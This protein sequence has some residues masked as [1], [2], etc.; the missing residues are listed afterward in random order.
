MIDGEQEGPMAL[1]D[2]GAQ[3]EE[4]LSEMMRDLDKAMRGNKAASQRVRTASVLFT[5]VAK[6]FRKESIAAEK[7][8]KR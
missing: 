3:V 4:L 6:L 7:K 5:K 2:T 8:K 1:K